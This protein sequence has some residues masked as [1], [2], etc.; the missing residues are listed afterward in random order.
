[1]RQTTACKV[2]DLTRRRS[3]RSRQVIDFYRACRR[4]RRG[5]VRAIRF[6]GTIRQLRWALVAAAFSPDPNGP[7]AA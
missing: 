4:F 1:M 5:E 2:R 7:E 3:S 6:V